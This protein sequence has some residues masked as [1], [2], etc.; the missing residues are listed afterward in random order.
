M[1]DLFAHPELADLAARSRELPRAPSCRPSGLCT[2]GGRLPL[3]FAQQ[4]L[5]FL[6]QMEGGA[7]PI[8]FRFA[9]V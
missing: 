5:W 6:A 1:R 9:C 8:T 7:R 2:R 4:R 3:S